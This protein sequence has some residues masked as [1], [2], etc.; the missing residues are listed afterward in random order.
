MMQLQLNSESKH[1][2]GKLRATKALDITTTRANSI[3]TTIQKT[4]KSV[5]SIKEIFHKGLED[6]RAEKIKIRK[7]MAA[8][9]QALMTIDLT[10]LQKQIGEE[11]ISK[12]KE[13]IAEY[14][15]NAAKQ[16][17]TFR[18]G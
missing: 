11:V 3:T 17:T 1:I 8:R 7:E 12:A 10:L 2:F 15:K 18:R 4:I 6:L 5:S 13:D 14:V 9:K 16:K